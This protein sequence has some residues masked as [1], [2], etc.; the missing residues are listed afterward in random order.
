V[1]DTVANWVVVPSDG[2][3]DVAADEVDASFD[4]WLGPLCF[5]FLGQILENG[6]MVTG[7]NLTI[8]V[9][10]EKMRDAPWAPTALA[11]RY[12]WDSTMLALIAYKGN[13]DWLWSLTKRSEARLVRECLIFRCTMLCLF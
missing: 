10:V 4:I 2:I 7:K 8:A 1:A 6:F 3:T 9:M 5:L 11:W 12:P 13:L